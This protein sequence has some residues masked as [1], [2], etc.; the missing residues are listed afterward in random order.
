MPL[1]ARLQALFDYQPHRFA[2]RENQRN[3]RRVMIQPVFAPIVHGRRQVKIPALHF[4]LAIAKHFLGGRA[5][6]NR[7]HPGGRADGLLRTAEANVNPLLVHIDR[8]GGERRHRIH[9]QKGP[10]FVGNFS[11][12]VNAG[13]HAGGSLPVREADDLDIFA[14]ASPAHIFGIHRLA[15]R[16]LNLYDFRRRPGGNLVHALR[17]NAVDCHDAFIAFFERIQNRRFNPARTRRRKR[18]GDA[19]FRLKYL[20]QQDLRLVHAPLEPRI[21]MPHQRRGH[22][23]IDSRVDRRRPGGQHQPN[24]RMEFANVLRHEVLPFFILAINSRC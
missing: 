10:Q 3:R 24:G 4:R 21:H 6:G 2:Q 17:K 9:N 14:L 22:R 12:G 7:R 23:A 20:P 11:V 19:V 1:P 8:H 18:H 5:H 15:I 16:R 13:N